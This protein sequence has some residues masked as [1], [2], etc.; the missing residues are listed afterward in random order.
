MAM[1]S[2]RS[3][4]SEEVA[5]RLLAGGH[6][7]SRTLRKT[8]GYPICRAAGPRLLWRRMRGMGARCGQTAR[9]PGLPAA[10]ITIE[11]EKRLYG[12]W[13]QTIPRGRQGRIAA[14]KERDSHVLCEKGDR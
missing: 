5:V 10:G 4:I 8:A 13:R 2:G 12:F 7:K 9:D 3:G 1:D 14:K 6:T 11:K